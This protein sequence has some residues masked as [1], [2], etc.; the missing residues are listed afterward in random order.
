MVRPSQII[1]L[2]LSKRLRSAI[3]PPAYFAN[4]QDIP[5]PYQVDNGKSNKDLVVEAGSQ[6]VP[7]QAPS[8]IQYNNSSSYNN[9]SSQQSYP[10][11]NDGHFREIASLLAMVVLSY[12]AVD[13]YTER[14]KLEKLHNQTTAINLKALQIQQA[15][16]NN[17]RKTRDLQML[18]ERK[19]MAKRT[20]K[21]G[22]H[23]AILRK[24][25][26]E[27]GIDPINLDEAVREF[28]KSVRA[29]NSSKNVSDQ[30]LWLDDS[31]GKYKVST[32]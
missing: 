4:P 14:T 13:N 18:Q 30:Y 7:A 21:M 23:I 9:A 15:A 1:R 20:F 5:H 2:N 3:P 6:S 28:E 27:A 31:S 12:I 26:L 8:A 10:H 24:Q 22:L 25:L 19:E 11:S 32:M 16:H 29:D 17:D